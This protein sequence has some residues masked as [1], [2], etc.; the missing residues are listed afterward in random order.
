MQH[1]HACGYQQPQGNFCG[2]CGTALMIDPVQAT[3]TLPESPSPSNST[4]VQ[5]Q[6]K[7]RSNSQ[8]AQPNRLQEELRAY[9]TYFK[10]KLKNPTESLTDSIP[11][12]TFII[13]LIL[14]IVSAVLASYGLVGDMLGVFVDTRSFLMSM[15]LLYSLFMVISFIATYLATYFF[16]DSKGVLGTFKTLSGF[17]PVAIALNTVS[18]LLGVAGAEKMAFFLFGMAILLV[19]ILIGAFVTVDAVRQCSKSVNGFYAYVVYFLI[20][21]VILSYVSSSI[22]QSIIDDFISSLPF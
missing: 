18:F 1:C 5:Y 9:L 8:P 7:K 16:A 22:A 6:P 14:L 12:K 2:G 20:S 10:E 11:T 21:F 19:C 15:T 17:Y 3:D 13:N 4:V